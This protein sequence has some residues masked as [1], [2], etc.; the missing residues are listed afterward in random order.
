MQVLTDAQWA[1]FEAAIAAVKLRGARPRKED[2]RTIEAIIWRLD[3]GAKWRSIPAELG[4]W[5]HAYLRFRRWAVSGV[6]D[7]V[8]QHVVAEGEP[9]LAFACIDGTV[10]RAHQKAAGARPSKPTLLVCNSIARTT[11]TSRPSAAPAAVSVAR[12]LA[13]A[14]PMAGLSILSWCPGRRTNLRLRCNC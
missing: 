11:A 10:A 2:R 6:W 14:T 5:H 4:D 9:K 13:F 3:N 1:K 8:M 12:S 7:R